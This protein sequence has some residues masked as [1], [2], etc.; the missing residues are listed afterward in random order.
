M[1]GSWSDRTVSVERRGGLGRAQKIR[2][3]GLGGRLNRVR[4]RAPVLDS[5][6]IC[7]SVNWFFNTVSLFTHLKN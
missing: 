5:K 2:R 1:I 4:L 7:V 3:Q 6:S